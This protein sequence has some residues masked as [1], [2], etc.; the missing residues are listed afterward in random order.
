VVLQ[1]LRQELYQLEESMEEL[2]EQSAQ[3]IRKLRREAK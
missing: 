3:E 2:R 1:A